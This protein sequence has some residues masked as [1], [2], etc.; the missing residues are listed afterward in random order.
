MPSD[1]DEEPIHLL[2]K[3]MSVRI[4]GR[5]II[6]FS[7]IAFGGAILANVFTAI[8]T[9]IISPYTTAMNIDLWLQ[10]SEYV[11]DYDR[12]VN[13]KGYYTYDVEMAT[14]HQEITI[15]M[16]R[17]GGPVRIVAVEEIGVG[18]LAN[19]VPE[20]DLELSE[21]LRHDQRRRDLQTQLEAL[22]SNTRGTYNFLD[23]DQKPCQMI[24]MRYIGIDYRIYPD[25][26]SQ[27]ELMNGLLD[28]DRALRYTHERIDGV[29]EELREGM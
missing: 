12:E 22:L 4:R 8:L 7:I 17:R 23:D 1:Q 26:F 24:D 3:L 18:K 28:I 2:D 16:T 14:T 27:H 29:M 15:H 25:A 19:L 21:R 5:D 20:E 13:W 9:L 11:E 10:N 6:G